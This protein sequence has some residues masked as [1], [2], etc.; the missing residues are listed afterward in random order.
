MNIA[1]ICHDNFGGAGNAARRLHEGLLGLGQRSSLLV[2]VRQGADPATYVIPPRDGFPLSPAAGL[3]GHPDFAASVKRWGRRVGRYGNR[4]KGLELFTDAGA[5]SRFWDMD[6]VREADAVILHWI[7]GVI[8]VAGEALAA[9]KGKAVVWVL[10]DMNPFTGGCHYAMGCDR[11]A[12]ACGVCP[13]LGSRRS[14]DLSR[15]VFEDKLRAYADLDFTV[16]TPSRWLAGKAGAGSLM[17]G[18]TIEVVPNSVPTDIF[19]PMDRAA[20]RAKLGIPPSASVILFGAESLGN[21]RKGVG[22]LLAAL[23]ILAARKPDRDI[24]LLTFGGG[25]LPEGLPFPAYHAGIV[26][27]ESELAAVYAAADVLAL[28]SLADNLPNVALEAMA[29][30]LPTVCF[31][32]GGLPEIVDS[33]KTG[34]LAP[35]GDDAGFAEALARVLADGRG[36]YS[37]CREEALERY[38][39]NVQASRFVSLLERIVPQEAPCSNP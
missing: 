16:V 34:L 17:R 37:R 12:Q 31:A 20:S 26:R 25:T 13:Q 11:Y 36:P 39:L 3:G 10:H 4:P 27:D 6:Q 14:E 8:D 9:L 22:H 23:D 28:P 21:R 24:A 32:I 5:V 38:S 33:G 2:M 15:R 19:R 1:Q 7:C 18:R 29:C 35:P 30:G